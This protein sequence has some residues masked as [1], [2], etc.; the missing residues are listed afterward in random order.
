MHYCFINQVEIS[1]NNSVNKKAMPFK[2]DILESTFYL[3]KFYLKLN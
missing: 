1:T 3:K 2:D